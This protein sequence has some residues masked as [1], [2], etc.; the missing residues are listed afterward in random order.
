MYLTIKQQL[1]HLSKD[2]YRILNSN[3]AQQSEEGT[4]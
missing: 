3:M 1:K 4:S 2:D